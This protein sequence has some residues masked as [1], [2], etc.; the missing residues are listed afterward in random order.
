MTYRDRRALN[1]VLLIT[2][3]SIVLVVTISVLVVQ[4]IVNDWGVFEILSGIGVALLI[5]GGF[6]IYTTYA[7]GI[8]PS[9]LYM[10]AASPKMAKA[11]IEYARKRRLTIPI[12]SFSILILGVIFLAIGFSQIWG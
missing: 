6:G 3:I 7:G 1:L 4:T 12:I 2:V 9:S 5:I 10:N 11:E 8:S